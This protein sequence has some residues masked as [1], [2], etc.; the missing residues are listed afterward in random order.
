MGM[1][2]AL[3]GVE[4]YVNILFIT[5]FIGILEIIPLNA[6]PRLEI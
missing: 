2:V 6:E 4:W 3:V 1:T 5:A